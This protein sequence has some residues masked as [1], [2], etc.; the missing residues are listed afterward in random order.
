MA[1]VGLGYV[2]VLLSLLLSL[3][4]LLLDMPS[5]IDWREVAVAMFLIA[6]VAAIG[7]ERG[8]RTSPAADPRLMDA[9]SVVGIVTSMPQPGARSETALFLVQAITLPDGSQATVEVPV[10]ATFPVSLRAN[11]GDRLVLGGSFTPLEGLE[12]G[13]RRYVSGRQATG[14]FRGYGA[15]IESQGSSPLRLLVEMRRDL[16]DRLR[17]AIP[18]DAGALAA[19]IVTGDDS[20][21]GDET[22][23]AFKIAGLSHVTAVSGQNIAM[24][25]GLMTLLLRGQ[26][27]R[28][29]LAIQAGTLC[30]IWLYVG[31]TGFGAPAIRAGLFVTFAIVAARFGRRPDFLTILAV[32][33][34]GMLLVEPAF[35]ASVSFWLSMAAAAA[36]VTGFGWPTRDIKAWA[37][38][39]ALAL[40]TAQL[41][42]LPISIA[43]FGA[44]SPGSIIANLI[45][46]PLM[47]VAFPLCFLL[48]GSVYLVPVAAP[49]I[50]L[51]AEVVLVAAL[52]TARVLASAFP[53]ANLAAGG[54]AVQMAA[55][56][57]CA[58]LVALLSEDARRWRRRLGGGMATV[59]AN[60]LPVLAGLVA[61]VLAAILLYTALVH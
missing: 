45:V 9:T 4:F 31:M 12:P 16:T 48:A 46:G 18:G 23:Q 5:R 25:A 60:R 24:L 1:G 53:Q 34:G 59:P 52:A 40:M 30:L 19:G 44:W 26:A 43:I 22:A 8:N 28:R 54:I 3:G 13:Y 10:L 42:T 2:G 39:L 51:G 15:A 49:V 47:Q 17:R 35:A 56:I 6:T 7:A 11:V 41:A 32:I 36:L 50:A 21:L 14:V 58:V 55:G 33:S 27:L 20:A 61:G 29:M 57:P 37:L 38:R